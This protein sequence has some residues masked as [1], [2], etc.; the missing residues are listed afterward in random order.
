MVR[1]VRRIGVSK[2][3]QS[4]SKRSPHLMLG[5]ISSY[6]DGSRPQFSDPNGFSRADTTS[7]L[8][9]LTG[10]KE[11]Q[12]IAVFLDEAILS[13]ESF[14]RCA[15]SC[16]SLSMEAQR[17]HHE[18]IQCYFPQA[19]F[20]V[21]MAGAQDPH[22]ALHNIASQSW[23]L[24]IPIVPIVPRYLKSRVLECVARCFGFGLS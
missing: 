10:R 23:Q 20:V 21:G 24:M 7:L 2:G 16:V 15:I 18:S 12:K 19:R 17:P 6:N 13:F 8:L 1:T 3:R 11:Q 9:W 4:E 14:Q 5:H 22:S